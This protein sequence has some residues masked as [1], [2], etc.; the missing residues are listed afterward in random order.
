[1]KEFKKSIFTSAKS[2]EEIKKSI[3]DFLNRIAEND[4]EAAEI[5]MSAESCDDDYLNG[6]TADDS[7]TEREQ[8][9]KKRI[10]YSAELTLCSDIV[11]IVD[12]PCDNKTITY[13]T[14]E[15]CEEPVKFPEPNRIAYPHESVPENLSEQDEY[16][17]KKIAE[18]RDLEEISSDGY[19]SREIV[20]ITLVRQGEFMVDIEDNFKKKSS[21]TLPYP[22]HAGFSNSQ[23]RTYFTWRTNARRGVYTDVVDQY[24]V[25]Y[26]YELL[27]K[28][29]VTDAQDAL[30]RLLDVLKN[31]HL[32]QKY[33]DRLK[34]WIKD[35]YAFN[36]ISSPLPFEDEMKSQRDYRAISEIEEGNF[37]DKLDFLADN[38]V[39]E[40][41]KSEFMNENNRIIINEALER[42]L[43]ALAQYF[44][45]HGIELS[46]LICGEF[47][48]DYS[49]KPFECAIVDIKRQEGFHEVHISA[50]ERYSLYRKEPVLEYFEVSVLSGFVGYI[51]KSIEA[52]LRRLTS[53]GKYLNPLS[54][55]MKNDLMGRRKLSAIIN[56]P[57]FSSL[58]ADTVE[59]YYKSVVIAKEKTSDKKVRSKQPPRDIHQYDAADFSDD[60]IQN[61]ADF[62]EL[63]NQFSDDEF[64][65]NIAE[66]S[67][68]APEQDDDFPFYAEKDTL[69]DLDY[70]WRRFAISLTPENIMFLKKLLV[71]E[72]L[73]YCRQRD[74]TPQL[75]IEEINT[76]AL[77]TIDD[78]VIERG[79][80]L[81]DYA[82]EVKFIADAFKVKNL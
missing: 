23:L 28:I 31:T 1:M 68:Y 15:T 57:E 35:F 79:A 2:L 53:Y 80:V 11:D 51:L 10:R 62:E 76:A 6:E 44:N 13:I 67:E 19:I 48:T 45:K 65:E 78:V 63:T 25:L 46:A 12:S 41:N 50:V 39:Y 60:V 74:I 34:R 42:V 52:K 40:I 24:P 66:C 71:G 22:V 27:N 8:S 17:L 4:D 21:C 32:E 58:I 30:N 5:V 43:D 75:M 77:A 29:G 9:C 16:M 47:R 55:M 64:N 14:G 36:R 3:N 33:H 82:E 81:D 70:D 73:A 26:C 7:Y 37:S 20:E 72:E 59:D 18:M 69:E 49:W 54:N 38:S 56:A 61:S